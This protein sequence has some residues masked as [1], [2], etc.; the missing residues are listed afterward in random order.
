MR[1]WLAVVGLCRLLLMPLLDMADGGP[2]KIRRV[3]LSSWYGMYH[4]GRQTA[5]GEHFSRWH[6]TAAHWS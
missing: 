5:S 6:L 1:T 3:G 4:Q 2:S